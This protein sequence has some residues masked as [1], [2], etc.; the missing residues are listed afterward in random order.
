MGAPPRLVLTAFAISIALHA[1]AV[2]FL[3]H[4]RSPSFKPPLRIEVELAT[5]PPAPE[6]ETP[7]PEEHVE[8]APASQ[9]SP[10][11]S[12]APTPERAPAHVRSAPPAPPAKKTRP[13]NEV[14]LPV[15]AAKE[16][17]SE[18]DYVAPEV[19]AANSPDE[20]PMGTRPGTEP[21]TT[22]PAT[23][24][25]GPTAG[26]GAG[27]GTGDED[28]LLQGYLRRLH[29]RANRHRDYPAMALRRGW[30]GRVRVAVSFA[31]GGT[32]IGVGLDRSS[33]HEVLDEQAI[34]MVRRAVSELPIEARLAR[35]PLTVVVPVEFKLAS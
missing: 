9:L 7:V 11:S 21:F 31:A 4:F 20:L 15:L 19:P 25:D 1:L 10:S 34:K 3:P 35:R 8:L 6:P 27:D 12:P 17:A 5:P 29:E 33:G 22:P 16:P 28:S 13:S 32:V 30:Q 14:A 2:F 24:P 26:T 23:S 18:K